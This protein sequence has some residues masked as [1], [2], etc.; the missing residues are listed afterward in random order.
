MAVYCGPDPILVGADF[1]S[2]FGDLPDYGQKNFVILLQ[3]AVA[4]CISILTF[5]LSSERT[6]QD[7]LRESK[8][9]W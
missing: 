8:A 5:A 9:Y 4:P 7:L 3:V 1:H 6:R 2:R